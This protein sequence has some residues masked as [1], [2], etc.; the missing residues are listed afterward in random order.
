MLLSNITQVYRSWLVI[1][2]LCL[3]T[4]PGNLPSNLTGSAMFLASCRPR[5]INCGITKPRQTN[6]HLF[7]LLRRVSMPRHIIVSHLGVLPC[8]QTNRHVPGLCLSQRSHPSRPS[9]QR[10]MLVGEHHSV[11]RQSAKFPSRVSNVKQTEFCAVTPVPPHSVGL[12]SSA[13]S[14]ESSTRH[15]GMICNSPVVTRLLCRRNSDR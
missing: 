13:A 14:V 7:C 10:P 8:Q 15:A 9:T 2:L 5:T 12:L 3:S 6:I 1:P 11:R 4:K